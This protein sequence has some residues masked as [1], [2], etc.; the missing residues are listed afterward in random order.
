VAG[1]AAFSSLKAGDPDLPQPLNEQ[2]FAGLML[3]SP[4]TRTLGVSDSLILTG[5]ASLQEDMVATVFD[6]QT[7]VSHL[8]SR[9]PNPLGWQL[10]GITGSPSQLRTWTAKIQV[11]GGEVISVRYQKPPLKKSGTAGSGSSAPGGSSSGSLPPLSSAQIAE[12]KNAAVN[13]KEGFSSDGYPRQPP[14]EMVAKLS[15][16][17]STQREDINKQMLGWRNKGLGLEDRRKIYENLVERNLQGR[18]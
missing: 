17:S 3:A 16:L 2:D 1:L 6:T 18:R 5:V 11:A 7:Q 12:A 14:P 10:V 8:V 13:Y 15:R 9:K 4:F